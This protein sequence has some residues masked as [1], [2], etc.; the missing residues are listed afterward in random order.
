MKLTQIF[1]LAGALVLSS[2]ALAE[3]GGD[4]TFEKMMA[5]KDLA[6]EKY[7]ARE[8]KKAPVVSGDAN[9]KTT[10]DR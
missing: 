10:K 5:A 6:M 4:R 7:V 2:F 1:L 8:G 3:G 9:D